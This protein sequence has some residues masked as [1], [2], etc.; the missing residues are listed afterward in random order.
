MTIG[1]AKPDELAMVLAMPT[2]VPVKVV[3]DQ[4]SGDLKI[5]HSYH[6]IKHKLELQLISKI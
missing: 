2:I 4:V 5:L 6:V 3:Q 1:E